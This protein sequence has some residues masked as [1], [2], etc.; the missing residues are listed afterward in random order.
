VEEKCKVDSAAGRRRKV[1][2]ETMVRAGFAVLHQ[3]ERRVEAER[4]EE[5]RRGS[6]V[7]MRDHRLAVLRVCGMGEGG[8]RIGK[9]TEVFVAG[10]PGR[11]R[12]QRDGG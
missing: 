5:K 1:R 10:W 11:D 6:P 2:R 7:R 4:W 12:A 8:V 3:A 9:V